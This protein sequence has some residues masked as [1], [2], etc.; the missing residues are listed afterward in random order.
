MKVGELPAEVAGG[1]AQRQRLPLG[2]GV[3][4]L[5]DQDRVAAR[6]AEGGVGIAVVEEGAA[7]DAGVRVGD[8]L[9]SLSGQK[10]DSPE[11]FEEVVGKLPAGA[12][13]PML[14][15]RNGAPQ[16]LALTVPVAEGKSEGKK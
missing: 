1:E 14:I 10:I 2:L 6:V 16:F 12:S 11:K 9:L 4:R 3:E 8:I 15:Q 5:N 13:V 7:R